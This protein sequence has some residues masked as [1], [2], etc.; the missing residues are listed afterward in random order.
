MKIN[1]NTKTAHKTWILTLVY[2]LFLF[3]IWDG[4]PSISLSKIIE[5]ILFTYPLC[6]IFGKII[7]STTKTF[8]SVAEQYLIELVSF[9]LIG[10]V[11]FMGM[12]MLFQSSIIAFISFIFLF[13]IGILIFTSF[14]FAHL[15]VKLSMLKK[16]YCFVDQ[17][18]IRNFK[19]LSFT[20]CLFL[21]S[22]LLFFPKIEF[23]NI[24][25]E[26][27]ILFEVL[28]FLF[29]FLQIITDENIQNTIWKNIIFCLLI[30]LSIW[31]LFLSSAMILPN[32]KRLHFLNNPLL[33]QVFIVLII[34]LIIGNYIQ[35]K[36]IKSLKF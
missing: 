3:V 7:A 31:F 19:K 27:I 2:A 13:K 34:T 12:T 16:P 18:L 36:I 14:S 23:N 32:Q 26:S 6:L 17:Y 24:L 21:V 5:I 22:V 8:I 29:T 9:L 35:N 1:K 30:L 33:W 20:S 25:V 15:L 11:Y 28:L 10:F 4:H